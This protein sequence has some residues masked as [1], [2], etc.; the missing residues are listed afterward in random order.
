[1]VAAGR[2]AAG[3]LRA[4]LCWIRRVQLR[5]PL[6]AAIAMAAGAAAAQSAATD[7]PAADAQA[8]REILI[9]LHLPPPHFRPDGYHGANYRD[10]AAR[11]ARRRTAEALAREH[12]L[13]L[14]EDWAMPALNVDCYRMQL[15]PGAASAPILEALARDSRVKWAQPVQSYSAQAASDPLYPVQPAAQLWQLAEVRKVA[16]GR[17][18]LVAVVDSGIEADH[19]DLDGQV[20][21]QENFVDG[22]RY[23]SET[24]GTA[25]A[26]VIAA[27]AGNGVGIEGVAPGARLMAL[28]A[29]WQEASGATRCNSFTL[30]KALNYALL[31]GAQVINMSLSGPDDRLLQQLIGLAQARGVRLVGAYDAARPDGGFPASHPGVFAV[32]AEAAQPASVLVAPGRDIPTTLTGAR[33]GLVSGSSYAAAHVSGM[34]AVLTELKPRMA[35]AELRGTLVTGATASSTSIDMCATL[36]RVTGKCP[37][38]CTPANAS[39][40]NYARSP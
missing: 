15:P 39:A 21:V 37:C 14:V 29:C 26:G 20:A 12:G 18:V 23:A 35:L 34:M 2:Q 40:A 22:Q 10:D 6:L 33:W 36:T 16:T 7:A 11:A 24:H 13:A 4:A 32:A 19:P 9:M 25:V 17:K 38:G 31:H 28:R 30:A 1:M 5:V 27:H 8:P 3:P